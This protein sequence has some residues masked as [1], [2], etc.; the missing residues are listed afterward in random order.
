MKRKFGI[1]ALFSALTLLL[2]ACPATST[3][4][5]VTPDFSIAVSNAAP[6]IE[7]GATTTVTLTVTSTGGFSDQVA[8][9]ITN[10]AEVT[11]ASFNPA[12]TTSSTTLTL[13][14]ATAGTYSMPIT[15]TGGGITKNDTVTL[16]VTAGSAPPPP[17]TST[18]SGKVLD[19]NG[20]PVANAPVVVLGQDPAS[21]R[22]TTTAIVQTTNSNGEFTLTGVKKPYDLAIIESTGG[23]GGNTSTIYMGLTKDDPTLF[24]V[25][26]PTTTPNSARFTGSS[27]NKPAPQADFR[28]KG[29][30]GSPEASAVFSTSFTPNNSGNYNNINVDWF[31]PTATTGTMH[32]L[33]WKKQPTSSLP[34][35]F[36]GYGKRTTVLTDQGTVSNQDI[37]LTNLGSNNAGGSISV[38]TGYS[39]TNKGMAV[40]FDADNTMTF[41]FESGNNT[42]FNYVTPQVNGA[43]LNLL[44][45][46]EHPDG[47]ASIRTLTGIAL[48]DI[49]VNLDLP[50]APQLALPVNNATNVGYNTEFNWAPYEFTES[51]HLVRL[52]SVIGNTFNIITKD[53]NLKIPDLSAQG[54]AINPSIGPAGTPIPHNYSVLGIGPASSVNDA[55][56][57]NF[58]LKIL[59]GI[60]GAAFGEVPNSDFAFGNSNTRS[61]IVPSQ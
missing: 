12:T 18:I 51:V 29:V 45:V 50:D 57:P 30:Y 37:T 40:K 61:F 16:T 11:T 42:N 52:E 1:L 8:F 58:Q 19:L 24:S 48:D 31:G 56:T 34:L 17:A 7:E 38:P 14:S 49:N 28:H 41:A 32:V 15:A 39:V 20:Q 4:P 35:S 54:L 33:Q 5:K 55:A 26:I 9:S 6:S 36:T 53:S 23:P 3:V 59:A 25:K 60:L 43:T 22:L 47:R 27:G 2:T 46:A 10:P 13:G 21:N 44:A